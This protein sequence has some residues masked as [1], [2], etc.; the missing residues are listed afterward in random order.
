MVCQPLCNKFWRLTKDAANMDPGWTHRTLGARSRH[1]THPCG[2]LVSCQQ[3]MYL[4]LCTES[5]E[6]EEHFE[7][8]WHLH[9]GNFHSSTCKIKWGFNR[10]SWRNY[11][12]KWHWENE[13]ALPR[14]WRRWKVST[15]FFLFLFL[16]NLLLSKNKQEIATNVAC[17]LVFCLVV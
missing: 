17:C 1:Q 12:R 5:V 16:T 8:S 4:E 13:A 6:T 3:A 9:I 2:L 14:N 7:Q 10:T 11:L 15:I